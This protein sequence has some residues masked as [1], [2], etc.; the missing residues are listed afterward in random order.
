[1]LREKYLNFTCTLKYFLLLRKSNVGLQE[2][3][4]KKTFASDSAAV[5]TQIN[6]LIL[7]RKKKTKL[8]IFYAAAQNNGF[9]KHPLY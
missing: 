4:L 6:Y 2:T 7:P 9:K 8:K 5:K 3:I 1:M